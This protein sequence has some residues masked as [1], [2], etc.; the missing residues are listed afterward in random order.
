MM[1]MMILCS[2]A[3]GLFIASVF[4]SYASLDVEAG[5]S[6]TELTA[7]GGVGVLMNGICRMFWATLM[8]KKGFKFVYIIICSC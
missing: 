8:D 7:I 6:D 2:S 1:L 5:Y 3:Y 4:K